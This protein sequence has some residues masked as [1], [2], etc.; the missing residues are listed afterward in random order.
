M[1]KLYL[2]RRN[3]VTL[4]EKLDRVREGESSPCTIIKSDHAHPVY[5]QSI[6]RIAVTAAETGDQYFPG[7]SQRLNLSRAT[8]TLLLDH[9]DKQVDSKVEL[10]G[11]LVTAVHDDKY[12]V[13]RDGG[14]ITPIGHV[15]PPPLKK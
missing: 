4:L 10:N 8:L 5:P 3:I 15:S 2:S 11:M 6:R 9:F 14:N 13:D 12:Y 7:V 1:E